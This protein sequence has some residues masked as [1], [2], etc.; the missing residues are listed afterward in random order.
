MLFP[1]PTGT[2][3][4]EVALKIA[5]KVKGRSNVLAL[6][7]AFHGMSLGS[8]A[9]TTE[10]SAREACGVTLGNVTH[11]PHPSIMPNFDT[12]AYIEMLLTNDHSGVD[13]PAALIVE[14]IQGEGGIYVLSNEW[15]QKARALCDKYDMLL[16]L[17]DI[18]AG[19]CRTGTF[20]SFERAGIVPDIVVMAKSIGGIGMPC[21]IAL[22]K[23]EYDILQPGEHNGT[24]R[25]F[26]LGFVAGKAAIEFMISH[27]LEEETRRKGKIVEEYLKSHLQ[28]I[29][30][31]L[32]FRGMGLMWGIDMKSYPIGTTQIIRKS[33]FEHGL[34]HTVVK[35]MPPLVIN[36]GLLMQGLE[37]LMKVLVETTRHM[38]KSPIKQQN[39]KN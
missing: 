34:I 23:P 7:G 30:P 4:I 38:D 26:Q 20:F 5:R 10:R 36:D 17:D 18:Q 22:V 13:K 2:N 29:D 16:I 37:I 21:S 39:N 25:G 8:L 6:M 19:C 27:N 28:Q 33:C 24:F 3:A 31:S 1:G 9:L 12:I 35:I 11:I 15:L 32:T 14:V